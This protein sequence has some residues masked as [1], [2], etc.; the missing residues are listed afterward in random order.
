MELAVD[1]LDL[2]SC[3]RILVVGDVML[4]RYWMGDVNRI[5]PEAPVPVVA[6]DQIDERLGGAGNVACNI[7]ALG[8]HCTLLGLVG[9]DAAG[10]KANAVANSS[11]I[12]SSLPPQSGVHTTVKLR[13]LSRNQQLIRV[14]FEKDPGGQCLDRL[15]NCF[16]EQIEA[17]DVVVFS[18]YGKG[19]LEHIE[20]L[21]QL[22]RACGKPTLVDPKGKYF[23]RYRNSTMITPNL[24]EFESVVGATV[25][26]DDIMSKAHVLIGEC[27]VDKLL[28]TLSDKGMMLVLSDGSG[29]HIPARSREVF[30]VSGAGDTVMAVIAMAMAV[31]MEDRQALEI[32]NSAAGIVISKLGTATTSIDTL[33]EA[34]LRDYPSPMKQDDSRQERT[35]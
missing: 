32:A 2:F 25:D 3:A 10:L 29:M 13:I 21:I 19:S 11:G 34:M 31:G 5:S 6:V 17:C 12:V 33:K 35:G 26:K 28:I 27:Q 8:G 1:K 14:D 30:D 4:D 15:H 9:D 22:A 23:S 18:D 24:H 20:Q 16:A 7:T